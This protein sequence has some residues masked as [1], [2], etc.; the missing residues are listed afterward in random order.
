[1]FYRGAQ[2]GN[3][4]AVRDANG[5]VQLYANG[6]NYGAAYGHDGHVPCLQY[7]AVTFGPFSLGKISIFLKLGS[8]ELNLHLPDMAVVQVPDGHEPHDDDESHDG[9]DAASSVQISTDP[10]VWLRLTFSFRPY[11]N[12]FCTALW[13]CR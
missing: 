10:V 8:T 6:P 2:H 11:I 7:L 1:M 5:T 12:A 3:E 13:V 9:N 4:H